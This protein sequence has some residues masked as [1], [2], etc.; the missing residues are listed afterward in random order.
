[1]T[2][3]N[4]SLRECIEFAYGI[5]TGREYEMSGPGWLD[6]AKFDLAATFPA[7]TSRDHV[8]EMLQALLADRFGLKIHF[9]SR[10]N[11]HRLTQ[12]HTDKISP[13]RLY[14]GSELPWPSL[15][16]GYPAPFSSSI[17]Q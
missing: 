13:V 8:R 6:A 1:M 17:G 14:L 7:E 10:K 12:I 5:P 4:V 9:E 15:P 16:T 2:L 11:G 3:D